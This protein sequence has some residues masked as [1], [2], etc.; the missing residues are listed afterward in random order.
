MSSRSLGKTVLG[1]N[2]PET[3]KKFT[4]QRGGERI[5]NDKFLKVNIQRKVVEGPRFR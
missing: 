1:I 4:S 5:Y 3:F 2:W